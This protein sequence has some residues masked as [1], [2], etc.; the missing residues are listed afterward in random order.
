MACVQVV[1]TDK[2][3]KR[4][5]VMYVCGDRVDLESLGLCHWCAKPATALCDYPM[6]DG[7][8]CS[9]SL[10][11]EHRVRQRDEHGSVDVDFCPIHAQFGLRREVI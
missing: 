6:G 10:C 3:S 7:K 9:L 11:D 1:L 8:T 4:R 2:R 5:Q